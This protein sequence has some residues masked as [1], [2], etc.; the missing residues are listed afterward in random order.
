MVVIALSVL[1]KESAMDLRVSFAEQLL[2]LVVIVTVGWVP[3]WHIKI[4]RKQ[5]L[6]I[7]SL[8]AVEICDLPNTSDAK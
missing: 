5:L 6:W 4:D 1:A 3:C 7:P 2:I 8:V